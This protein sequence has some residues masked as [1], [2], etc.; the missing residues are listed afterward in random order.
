MT[1]LKSIFRR[2]K[3][4]LPNFDLDICPTDTEERLINDFLTLND[5]WR[6]KEIIILAETCDFLYFKV[7]QYAI[8][9]DTNI[10]VRFAALKRIHLFEEHPDL[11]PMLLQLKSDQRINKLEPYFSMALSRVGL[12][13]T[14]E[15]EHKINGG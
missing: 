2:R 8:L 6:V 15:F 5:D 12:I 11:K 13:T 7:M 10:T 3:N 9:H 14:Q 4:E 1:F